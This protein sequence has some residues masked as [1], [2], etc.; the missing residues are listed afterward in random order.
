MNPSAVARLNDVKGRPSEK[1]YALCLHTARQMRPF[2]REIPRAATTLMERFWPGPLT[3]VLPSISG[4]TVGF[5][6]PDHP[7]ARAFLTACG[8]PVAAPSANRS[9][10]PPPTDAN[11]VLTALNGTFD[12]LLDGGPTTLGRESTVVEAV[13]GGIEIR[14]E[15]AIAA[16]VIVSAVRSDER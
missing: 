8:I 9:G 13:N 15:G 16:D 14:R 10:A 4:G 3:I 7:V 12:C 2:V 1:P 5:R 6:L 11:E